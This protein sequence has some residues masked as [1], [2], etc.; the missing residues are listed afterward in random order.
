[1]VRL[2]F[3]FFWGG[4]AVGRRKGLREIDVE[5][6]KDLQQEKKTKFS[7]LDSRVYY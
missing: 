2:L 3:K 4:V 1:M 6:G 5:K 7:S